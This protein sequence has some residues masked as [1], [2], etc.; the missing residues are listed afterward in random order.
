MAGLL[1]PTNPKAGR[2]LDD[3]PIE[4]RLTVAVISKERH[5][6]VDF[7]A[8]VQNVDRALETIDGIRGVFKAY[9]D[10]NKR[11]EMRWRKDDIYCKPM[12]GD[13]HNTTKKCDVTM[14]TAMAD[15]QYLPVERKED[16][17]CRNLLPELHLTGLTG[18]EEFLSRDVPLFMPPMIFSR[19][20]TPVEYLYRPDK[21]MNRNAQKGL[22]HLP[23]HLIGTGRQKRT[24]YT[25]FK[26]F[27]EDTPIGPPEGAEAFLKAKL[28]N[29]NL[30]QLVQTLFEERPI[31]SK[32][33]I[34]CNLPLKYHPR[35]KYV[36]PLVA[37]YFCNGPW[38]TLWVKF[39][40]DPRKDRNAKMYQILDFRLR[41]RGAAE[42]LEIGGKRSAFDYK[43]P[44]VK[45]RSQMK[46]P[47][48]H[49]STLGA[50]GM[51]PSDKTQ[52]L[53]STYMFEPDV[54]PPY[55]Q[56]FY[57]LCDVHEDQIQ[58]LLHQ[59]DGQ[60]SVCTERE[61]WLQPDVHDKSSEILFK[62]VDNILGRQLF[63][64]MDPGTRRGRRIVSKIRGLLDAPEE[65]EDDS[66]VYP[67]VADTGAEEEE[68][69]EMETE[70]LDCI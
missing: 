49:T 22:D 52:I 66:E 21:V 51:D 60:E 56:M 59:N 2:P 69:N 31:W 1:S 28:K 36:L 14:F 26:T 24:I 13:R 35:L 41:Q 5:V 15:Y 10:E 42:K 18:R 12:Y 8:H 29:T 55:R 16:G 50:E 44:T 6:C 32:N 46:I 68:V 30:L 58:K 17:S 25:I 39:G 48:I 65:S 63:P 9:K 19:I 3:N 43:L 20:D 64:I 45:S 61:G 23:P 47:K 67:I 33:G 70:M 62:H 57:Q 7:P 53:E 27:D 38:R 54:L 34:R 11:L 40:Y 37:Y 4:N